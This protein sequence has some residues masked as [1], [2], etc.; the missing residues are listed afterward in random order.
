[1]IPKEAPLRF[2]VRHWLFWKEQHIQTW[3]FKRRDNKLCFW[4]W[5]LTPDPASKFLCTI[6]NAHYPEKGDWYWKNGGIACLTCDK[7]MT[8]DQ[9]TRRPKVW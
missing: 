2:R 7:S 9:W 1:M 6:L 3:L 5:G 8:L 4:L